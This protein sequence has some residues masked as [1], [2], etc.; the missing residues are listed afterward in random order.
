MI[1]ARNVARMWRRTYAGF[2]LE[3]QKKTGSLED[4]DVVGRIIFKWRNVG[5]LLSS[6]A[7]GSLSRK[8]QLHSY[9]Y[10]GGDN[11]SYGYSHT[12]A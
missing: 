7:T 12:H 4:L 3:S 5:H 2:W 8:T 11:C 10:V 9:R 6:C 1:W